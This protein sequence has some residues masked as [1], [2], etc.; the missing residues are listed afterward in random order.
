MALED[1]GPLKV[2]HPYSINTTDENVGK[3][4]EDVRVFHDEE[5][6]TDPNF[7]VVS[8]HNGQTK[9]VKGVFTYIGGTAKGLDFVWNGIKKN[10]K[11]NVDPPYF[12]T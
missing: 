12:L 6:S 4:R 2:F 3:V 10:V 11:V 1:V 8:K 9:P 5:D 7:Y